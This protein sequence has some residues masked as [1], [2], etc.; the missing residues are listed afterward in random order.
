MFNFNHEEHRSPTPILNWET[1]KI[2]LQWDK[3][4]PPENP[5]FSAK[6]SWQP[7]ICGQT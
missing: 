6:I 3:F 4:H 5:K 7:Q 2:L 1:F